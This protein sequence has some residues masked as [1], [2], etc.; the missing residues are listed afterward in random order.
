MLIL[1][2]KLAKLSLRI[3]GPPWVESV[4][5]LMQDADVGLLNAATVSNPPR[6]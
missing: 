5:L 3:E 1:V 6:C 2:W 4:S